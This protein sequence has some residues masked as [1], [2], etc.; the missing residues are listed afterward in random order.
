METNYYSVA[1]SHLAMVREQNAIMV[2][3][4]QEMREL[5]NTIPALITSARL[6]VKEGIQTKYD[7]D[8]AAKVCEIRVA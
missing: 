1:D 8:K 7:Y 2:A 6:D 3:Q 4:I 5:I